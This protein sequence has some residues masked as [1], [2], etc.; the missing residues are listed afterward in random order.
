METVF[1]WLATHFG[2]SGLTIFGLGTY[3][4][5]KEKKHGEERNAWREDVKLVSE[6]MVEVLSE[7]TGVLESLKSLIES[8]DR[9][10]NGR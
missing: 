7:N 8:M 3:I 2:L 9:R 5:L 4:V 6:K 10:M 1:T